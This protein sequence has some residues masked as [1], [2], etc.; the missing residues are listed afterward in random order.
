M[1]VIFFDDSD[2]DSGRWE[3]D[4]SAIPRIGETTVLPGNRIGRVVSV[5]WSFEDTK[6]FVEITLTLF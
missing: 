1:K 5:Q 2:D 6:P 4:M 3:T